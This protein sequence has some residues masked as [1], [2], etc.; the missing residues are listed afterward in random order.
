MDLV[1][2]VGIREDQIHILI[3]YYFWK[4]ALFGGF[5][6]IP[7]SQNLHSIPFTQYGNIFT[8][9]QIYERPQSST[10]CHRL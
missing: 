4:G 3:P 8:T 7:L 5:F 6:D 1:I 9:P 2:N 10:T